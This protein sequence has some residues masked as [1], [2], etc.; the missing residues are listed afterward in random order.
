MYKTLQRN[1]YMYNYHLI[2][3]I[4]SYFKYIK[5][6]II[7]H[8]YMGINN[9]QGNISVFNQIA[10]IAHMTVK[11]NDNHG[12]VTF[13]LASLISSTPLFSFQY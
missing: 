2:I 9:T 11:N 3:N 5:L 1:K 8:M 6:N 13:K 12:I 10:L 7:S 4:I